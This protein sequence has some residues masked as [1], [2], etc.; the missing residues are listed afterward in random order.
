MHNMLML[1]TPS[2]TVK[3]V[4]RFPVVKPEYSA[5]PV[6]GVNEVSP[7]VIVA[8]SKSPVDVPLLSVDASTHLKDSAPSVISSSDNVTVKSCDCVTGLL[9]PVPC[10]SSC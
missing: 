6:T 3:V 8:D 10:Y 7:I 9:A 1:V 4:T 2:G 5:C